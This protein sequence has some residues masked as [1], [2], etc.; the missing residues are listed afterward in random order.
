L[1]MDLHKT[2][3]VWYGVRKYFWG[4][5]PTKKIQEDPAVELIKSLYLQHKEY[6]GAKSEEVWDYGTWY[7]YTKWQRSFE[8]ALPVVSRPEDI[9]N[10]NYLIKS[11]PANY[12]FQDGLFFNYGKINVGFPSCIGISVVFRSSSPNYV[13]I[14]GNWKLHSAQNFPTGIKAKAEFDTTFRDMHQT[15]ITARALMPW[16]NR[17]AIAG[18]EQTV[19]FVYP[20]KYE[21]EVDTTISN[22]L[23]IRMTSR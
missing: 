21:L 5:Y 1:T 3:D 15:H 7:I 14:T 18:F 23:T 11:L 6:I 19:S 13:S 4:T 22:D 20:F 2:Q 9:F 16:N 8:I 12:D 17:A 10:I